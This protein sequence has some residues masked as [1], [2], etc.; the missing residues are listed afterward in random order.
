MN[1]LC[2]GYVNVQGCVNVRACVKCT[3]LLKSNDH[4]LLS[5]LYC[6]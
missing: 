5:D 6:S 3:K 2:E 4:I 1:L